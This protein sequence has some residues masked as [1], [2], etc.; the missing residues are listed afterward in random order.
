MQ[1]ELMV[2]NYGNAQV[3]TAFGPLK[4]IALSS[5]SASGDVDT[6][7]VSAITVDGQMM[8]TLVSPAPFPS[9]LDDARTIL[10]WTCAA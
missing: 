2:T 5:G 3:R 8:M 9:L 6:Q 10:A 4:L 7:N 1:H